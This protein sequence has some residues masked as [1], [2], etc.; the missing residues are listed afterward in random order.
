M[1]ICRGRGHNLRAAT[2]NV[3]AERSPVTDQTR[4]VVAD[5]AA[6]LREGIALV[7]SRAGF[8]VV[9]TA[10]NAVDLLKLVSGHRPDLA[11]V[12]I[13]MPPTRTTEGIEAS[14]KIRRDFPGT[15]VVLL[16]GHVDFLHAL[17]LI[18]E[19]PRG[20]GYLLKDRVSDTAA[21][22]DDL[23][24]VAEGGTAI[25]PDLV[26]SLMSRRRYKGQ[27]AELTPKETAVLEFMAQGRSNAAIA[28]AMV[29]SPRTV[30][31]HINNVFTKLGL[32][33]D[34]DQNR[35]VAA[36]LEYLPRKTARRVVYVS[37][38]PGSLARDAGTLVQQHGF[39]LVAAGVMDMFPHTAHVESIALF[40]R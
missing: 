15:A 18:R 1:V 35:R 16:S 26:D 30:E 12:D 21:F 39:K 33:A 36:V 40:E 29:V 37:C 13:R 10:S 7:L 11:V 3:A 31:V 23:K 24:T 9:G 28:K 6:L 27:F 4:V 34:N 38:H 2:I 20:V 22:I 25:D 14:E 17:R 32:E 8:D 19:K 5:D